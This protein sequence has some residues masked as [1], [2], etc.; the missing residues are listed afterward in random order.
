MYKV[1]L[2][3]IIIYD[4]A[5]EISLI[6]PKVSL[7]ENKAGSFEFAITPDNTGY[8][9]IRKLTSSIGVYKLE[10]GKEIE[11]FKGRVLEV[12]KDFYNI[13][14]VYCEGELAFLS[15]SIQRPAE[16]HDVSA[17]ELLEILLDEHNCQVEDDKKFE[18]GI[19][20][21][22]DNN[23]SLYEYT[24]WETTLEDIRAKL[25]DSLGG[26]LSVRNEGGVRY[27]DYLTDY[28]YINQQVIEFG[29][30]LLDYSENTSAAD[31]ITCLI[32]LGAKL[33]ESEVE[34]L[35]AYTTIES[36]NG[37]KEY[38]TLGDAME[39][40]GW[41]TKVQKWD[42]IAVPSDLLRKGKEYLEKNQYETMTLSLSAIDLNLYSVEFERIKLGDQIR[43]KSNPH[44][45]DMFFPVTQMI[46]YLDQPDKNTIQLGK[47][48]K[49]LTSQVTSGNNE[50]KKELDYTRQTTTWLQSAIDNATQMMTGSKGGYKVTEF[51]DHGRWLRDLYMNAESKDLATQVM[52]INMNGIGFSSTGFNGPYKNAWTIDGV[53]LGEFIKAG[54]VSAE[55]LSVEYKSGVTSEITAKF[56]VA[57][58]L[59]SAEVT[60]AKGVESQLS[61][62]LQIQ[63]GLI[64]SKVSQGEFGSYM[65]QYYDRVIYGFNQNSKYVQ[66]NPGEIAVYDNGVTNSK[67][68]AVFNESGNHFYRDGYYVGKIGTNQWKTNNAFKGLE[69]DLE[70]QGKYMTWCY[71]KAE[72]NDYYTTIWT[73]SRE[74]SA[75]DELGL[76]AGCDIDMHNWTLKNVKLEGVVAGGYTGWSGTIPIITEIHS[77]GGGGIGWSYSSIKVANGIIISAPR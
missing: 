61:A 70:Y 2:D 55:K 69:F 73:F 57:N 12:E 11:I 35:E 54:S 34:G 63:A 62:S 36:V 48:Q 13:K 3:N 43:V 29:E 14:Q 22:H 51:D 10:K 77:T 21:V 19:V 58:N 38:I 30:N 41:V 16:Y 23:D 65:Q 18:A 76:H 6:E 66:I 1:Y 47:T 64:E 26:R 46:L 56:N 59:I 8:G 49:N 9:Q 39:H 71:M 20:T 17:R 50:I 5:Q 32:P 27:L 33:E 42:D 53:L 75:Y 74:N 31:I 52:Q 25:M 37:G 24:N 68:R 40:Y 72:N 60:R 28:S 45:M 15:D 7:E 44:G 4:L 67:K